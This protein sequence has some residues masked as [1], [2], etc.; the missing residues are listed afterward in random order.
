[1]VLIKDEKTSVSEFAEEVAKHLKEKEEKKY[2]TSYTFD[3]IN[4]L[5]TFPI[6]TNMSFNE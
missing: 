3:I 5:K 4:D 6:N 1:M 2:Q